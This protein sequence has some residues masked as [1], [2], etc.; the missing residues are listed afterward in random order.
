MAKRKKS[1]RTDTQELM[2]ELEENGLISEIRSRRRR[3]PLEEDKPIKK[4]MKTKVFIYL[5]G[6]I[7]QSIFSNQDTDLMV[8]DGDTDGIEDSE[9][10][11]YKDTL[12]S[13]FK[14]IEE[15]IFLQTDKNII[16]HYFKQRRK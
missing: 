4:I 15:D 1:K 12:G 16:D 3:K 14:A 10:R 7:I 2:E 5:K 8:L 11:I 9:I 13:K 6:G